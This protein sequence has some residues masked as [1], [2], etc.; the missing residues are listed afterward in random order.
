MDVSLVGVEDQVVFLVVF[1]YL[2]F[3]EYV[4]G[5]GNVFFVDLFWVVVDQV[6][7]EWQVFV[8]GNQVI[9]VGWW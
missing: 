5:L 2:G 1:G 3:V 8:F 4:F 9:V 6:V 7:L